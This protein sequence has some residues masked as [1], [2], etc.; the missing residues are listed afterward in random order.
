M[1]ASNPLSTL[2]DALGSHGYQ[3]HGQEHDFRAQCP[4]HDGDS[5]D[6]LHC[7]IGADGSA[8][9]YCFAHQC[10]RRDIA[11]ALGLTLGDLYPAGHHHARQRPIYRARRGDFDGHEREA[12]DML[13]ALQQ[14]G[15]EWHVE[16]TMRCSYCGDPRARFVAGGRFPAFM[17]CPG[18]CTAR[19]AAQA[20]AGRLADW[21]AER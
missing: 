6:A 18:G 3:P 9:L 13:Y 5:P 19:T 16:I 7:F 17:S 10:D 1:T 4:A 20:L 2:W 21:R 14:I 8:Q 12:V 11:Q 15:E